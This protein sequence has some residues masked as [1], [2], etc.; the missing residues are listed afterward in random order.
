[1]TT[2]LADLRLEHHPDCLVCSPGR[3]DGLK[4]TFELDPQGTAFARFDCSPRFQGFSGILHGGVI[5]TLLDGAM[6]NCLFLHGHVAVTA[7]LNV[8]Y[9][10]P[11]RIGHP[12]ILKARIEEHSPPL[13]NLS[14]E[15][16]QGEII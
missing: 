15:L 13:F 3:E 4:V 1:M 6:T 7:K 16:S 8:R 10:Q 14:A 2:P 9:R 11:V 12:A 5:S